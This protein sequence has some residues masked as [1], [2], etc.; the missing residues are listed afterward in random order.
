MVIGILMAAYLDAS[1]LALENRR[2][3][4]TMEHLSLIQDAM[5]HYIAR[6]GAY[7]CPAA[8]LS[9]GPEDIKIEDC[10][11]LNNT[12]I[13]QAE[14]HGVALIESKGGHKIM[15]GAVPYRQLNIPRESALDGWGNQFTYAITAG[16]TRHDT[17]NANDGGLGLSNQTSLINPPA[18]RPRALVFMAR[19]VPAPGMTAP[20]QPARARKGEEIPS[21][22]AMKASSLSR[23]RRV[24]RT[25]T[26]TMILFSI[27]PGSII[28]P[29]LPKPIARCHCRKV[30]RSIIARLA[31]Y[32]MARSSRFAEMQPQ[33]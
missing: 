25:M 11:I 27:A 29:G 16:L 4:V 24:P 20:P 2:R 8:P 33:H 6:N 23:R 12:D 31:W 26:F 5:A 14:E 32:R 18:S 30:P 28:S 15:E 22:A 19:T 1:R 10:A 3:S 17:F 9:A 21:I 7:P 13:E